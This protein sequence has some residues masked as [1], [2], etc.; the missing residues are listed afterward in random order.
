VDG[1]A[2]RACTTLLADT[3]GVSKARVQLI[4]GE[5]SRDKRFLISGM[6]PNERDTR[7]A[8]LPRLGDD[9]L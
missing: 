3:L 9:S 8:L 6:P 4:G 2:N 7:L 1:A 5:T